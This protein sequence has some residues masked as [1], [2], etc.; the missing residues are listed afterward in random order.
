[1]SSTLS[2]L[3][4]LT[5][6]R[7]TWQGPQSN[8]RPHPAPQ[9]GRGGSV[10][11]G[12]RMPRAAASGER[13]RAAQSLAQG[14]PPCSEASPLASASPTPPSNSTPQRCRTEHHAGESE[15]SPFWRVRPASVDD[16]H[17]GNNARPTQGRGRSGLC[18]V[19]HT[20][21]GLRASA[22]GQTHEVTFLVGFEG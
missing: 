3:S 14:S 12:F 5:L 21:L 22:D 19:S 20:K 17:H 16:N 7:V 13:P 10:S 11:R 2:A 6:A 9:A 8:V 4:P 18:P 15:Q 1:M